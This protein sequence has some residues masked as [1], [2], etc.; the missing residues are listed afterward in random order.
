[1]AACLTMFVTS[2][3]YVEYKLQKTQNTDEDVSSDIVVVHEK[4]VPKLHGILKQRSVSE[5]SDDGMRACWSGSD[6]QLSM[7]TGSEGDDNEDSPELSLIH[8]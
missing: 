6:R 3:K 7:T 1:M 4:G 8:I 2:L 5:S